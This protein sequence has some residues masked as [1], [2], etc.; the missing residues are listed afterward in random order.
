METRNIFLITEEAD[1]EADARASLLQYLLE[2]NII[3]HNEIN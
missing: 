3:K 2:N 1:T